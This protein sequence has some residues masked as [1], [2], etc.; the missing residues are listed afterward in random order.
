MKIP[1]VDLKAQYRSI[2]TE[3]DQAIASVIDEA[4]FIGGQ[5]I[6]DFEK[7]FATACGVKHCISTG[8]GTDT[9]YIIMKMLGIK[10]GDEVITVAN[11]WISSSETITQTGAKV[12]FVDAHPE[13][14]SIDESKIEEKISPRTKALIVVH[15]QGQACAM[16]EVRKIC[17]KHNLFLIEDCAQSH[18]SQY[19]GQLVGTFGIAASFSFYPGKNMGAYGDAGCIITNDDA[20]AERFRMYARHGALVKHHHKIEGINSRMDSLQAVV[21]I[22]KLKHILRWNQARIRAAKRYDNLLRDIKELTLPKVR[23][24]TVHT[25]H[26][27]VILAERRDQLK[28][29]LK[30]EGIETVLHYP[31]PL[32]FL[33]AYRYLNHRPEDFPV[34]SKLQGEIL[35]L[36][37]Y[38]ELSDAQIDYVAA[39]VKSFYH[40]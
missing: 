20:F 7:E 37:M 1:F 2:K 33:E 24:D 31:T 4:T 10:T 35:S 3:V 26:L 5:P 9:L 34:S 25:Y 16:N 39:S 32:P 28:E 36:P 6:T 21:L 27:Y 30:S 22:E 23:P 11:S 12:V 38:P 19:R 13:Y 18:F 17:A 14:Y 8:N 40:Q 15:L 29:Y